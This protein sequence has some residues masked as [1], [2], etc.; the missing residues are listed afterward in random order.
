MTEPTNTNAPAEPTYQGTATYCPEDNKLRLYVGRVPRPDYDRL[1]A[2]GWVA[3]PKQDCDFAVVWTPDRE[4]MALEFAEIIEDEDKGPDERAA[5]R[6]ERFEEYRGKRMGEATGH[7]DGYDSQPTAHGY[8]SQA[9]AERAAARHDRQGDRAVSAWSKA[10]YW[11]SRTA[12]VISH[13]LYVSAPS[14]RMGRIKMIESEIRKSEKARTEYTQTRDR[15]IACAA[16]TDPAKQIVR[17]L[18]LAYIEHGDY[19]HPRDLGRPDDAERQPDP[20]NGAELCALYLAKHKELAPEGRWLTHYR[21]RLSYEEQMLQAQGGRAAHVEMEP[22]GFLRGGRRHSDTERQIMKVN[23]SH[24][25]GRVVSVVV[26]DNFASSC[27]HY[28]NPYPEGITRILSHTIETERMEADAY[29]APTPEEKAAWI[30]NEK[31]RKAARPKVET[32]PLLN[33]TD[34]DAERLQATWNAIALAEREAYYQ[35]Q[36]Y[37]PKVIDCEPQTVLRITQKTYSEASR[38][39]YGKASTREVFADG[40]E[41]DSYYDASRK[42]TEKHGKPVCQVRRTWGATYSASRVI[43]LTDKPQKALPAGMWKTLK[44]GDENC[45]LKTS[46]TSINKSKSPA[47]PSPS[48]QSTCEDTESA[49]DAAPPSNPTG[50]ATV[51]PDLFNLDAAIARARQLVTA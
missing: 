15:W 34:A 7:A 30:Q 20:L 28:G 51:Q 8:Q 39:T 27:N 49:S 21:L 13:A 45:A 50:A 17:A 3:T 25:T 44:G 32:I 22:G 40:I 42:M 5:D 10:E 48:G 1:R 43:I 36:G 35:R 11:Q 9:R 6:A 14:V 38:G 33:P 31:A 23:K 47:V 24:V 16:M 2:A 46:N 29:R 18:Q 19:T 41:C 26:R 4:D 12:G 37:T